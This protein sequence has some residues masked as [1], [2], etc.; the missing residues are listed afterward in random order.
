MQALR[1]HSCGDPA[2]VLR[3]ED[4]PTPQPGPGEVLVRMLAAPVNPSDRMFIAGTYGQAAQVPATA[5]FE[6]VGIVIESGGGWL[7]RFLKGRRVAVGCRWGGTWAEQLVLPAHNCVPL[8]SAIDNHQGAVFL[9]NPA[10]A[11]ILTRQLLK[12]PRRAW[13]IQSAGASHVGRMVVRLGKHFG[14]RTLS[15]VRR[16][17]QVALLKSLGADAVV[18]VP[19]ERPATL[20][21]ATEAIAAHLAGAPLRYALDPVGGPIGSLFVPLL[22]RGGRLIVYGALS[23]QPLEISPR[24]LIARGGGVESF[25]LGPWMDQLPLLGKLSLIR[26]LTGLVRRDVLSTSQFETYPLEQFSAALT[27]L[28]HTNGQRILLQCST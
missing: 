20:A 2:Q 25:W 9:V 16:T 26:K 23:D 27:G 19:D 10:T 18:H 8:P 21:A 28:N 1:F 24:D 15:L 7:G 14:F 22:D 5:G 17:E 6:G 11:Y 12:V 13:L 3:L 4:I